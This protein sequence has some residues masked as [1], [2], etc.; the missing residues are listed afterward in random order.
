MQIPF[1]ERA[2]EALASLGCSLN[3]CGGLDL[4][5]VRFTGVEP[6]LATPHRIVVASAVSAALAAA[7]A[8]RRWAVAR[9]ESQT[10]QIDAVQA[11]SALEPTHFQTQQGYRM[12]QT[13]HAR[14]LKS[15]FYKTGDGRWF[16]PSGSY[17]H[18]RDGTLELLNCPNTVSALAAAIAGWSSDDLEQACADR[19]LPGVYARSYQEWLAHPQG[20][21]LEVKPVIEIEKIGDSPAQ[22]AR[23]LKRP[24]DDIRVLDV[25]H[26]IAGPVMAR[27]LGE[28]GANVLRVS[29][30]SRPDPTPQILDTGIGKRNTYL[31]LRCTLGQTALRALAQDADVFI[32][33]WRPGALN[34]LG[35][36][37]HDL[38]SLRPGIIYASVSAFGFDGPWACRKGFDQMS[39][40]VTGIA[41][42]QGGEGRPSLVPSRLLNDY[43]TAYLGAAGVM[44]ALER[45][46]QSGGSYHVKVSLARTSMWVQELGTCKTSGPFLTM[47]DLSPTMQTRP[48]PFG[49]L[50]QLAPVA[51]LSKTP[52]GWVLPPYP[53][54]SHPPSW[55]SM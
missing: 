3:P 54:G 30:P 12:P 29:Q 41:V 17:P 43:L 47:D 35:F 13:S 16:M 8:A 38:A 44:E 51:I 34:A 48:S 50:E 46:A 55:E 20:L 18:L 28:F 42:A 15:G 36:S 33:S 9:G 1:S 49:L 52:A 27:T 19:S 22:M 40:A 2:D 26:V 37:P 4:N 7:C 21:A 39:Q 14:E 53:L 25:S 10:L 31:D 45:R 6:P 11:A 5:A 32:Q 23:P 24:L